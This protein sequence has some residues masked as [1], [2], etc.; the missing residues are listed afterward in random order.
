M[1]TEIADKKLGK[2]LKIGDVFESASKRMGKYRYGHC[3]VMKEKVHKAGDRG[4]FVKGK[5]SYFCEV[6]GISQTTT[7]YF[8]WRDLAKD[9]ELNK[10]KWAF[11]RWWQFTYV[12]KI[13]EN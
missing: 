12:V 7:G 3:L 4:Y 2:R 11:A 6:M 1:Q 10:K 5:R 8:L 13:I 9:G